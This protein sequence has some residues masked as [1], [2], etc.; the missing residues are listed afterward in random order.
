M[1]VIA[2]PEVLKSPNSDTHIIF[3]EAKIEDLSQQAQMEAAQK[4][5]AAEVPMPTELGGSTTVQPATIPEEDDDEVSV[6]IKRFFVTGAATLGINR[7]SIK[8][9]S[10]ADIAAVSLSVVFFILMLLILVASP[11]L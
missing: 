6:D 10:I 8:T 5:K 7:L 9:L 1:L 3:G 2:K 11:N 4:F